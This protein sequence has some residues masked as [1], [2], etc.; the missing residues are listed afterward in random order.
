[1]LENDA[2]IMKTLLLLYLGRFVITNQ[3]IIRIFF[4]LSCGRGWFDDEGTSAEDERLLFQQWRIEVDCD[5][6]SGWNAL[7]HLSSSLITYH[8]IATI[9][10]QSHLATVLGQNTTML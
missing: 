10:T 2:W 9:T 4:L 7:V 6:C 3:R 1:M 5:D 8:S